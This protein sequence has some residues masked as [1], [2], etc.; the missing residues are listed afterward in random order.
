MRPFTAATALASDRRTGA[1][2][3][4]AAAAAADASTATTALAAP[5]R[6]EGAAAVEECPRH[7]PLSARPS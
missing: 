3:A 2:P 4:A 7:P 6:G 5:P 1:A